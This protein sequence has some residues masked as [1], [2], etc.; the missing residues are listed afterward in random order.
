MREV[1]KYSVLCLILLLSFQYNAQVLPVL[2]PDRD[3]IMIGEHVVLTL[4]MPYD[5]TEPHDIVWPKIDSI[6]GQRIE[7]LKVSAIDTTLADKDAD[8]NIFVQ[9]RQ[10][11][12]TSFDS[13]YFAIPPFEFK[14]NSQTKKTN[15]VLITVSAPQVDI[16]EDFKEVKPIIEIKMTFGDYLKAYGKWIILI[17]V[18]ILL[19]WLLYRYLQKRKENALTK[20]LEEEKEVIPPYEVAISQLSALRSKDLFRQGMVKEHYIQLTDILREYIENQFDINATDETTDEILNELRR[21]NIHKKDRS[22]L[23][24]ILHLADFVK[25]AKAKPSVIDTENALQNSFDFIE[26]TKPKEEEERDEGE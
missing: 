13:G 11:I 21:I 17:V 23:S 20:G 26:K 5:I 18:L 12:V 1:M 2:Q 25:F 16:L 14:F 9:S 19:G 15:P 7:V 24:K 10:I 22:K 3:S 8:P 4:A 6:L